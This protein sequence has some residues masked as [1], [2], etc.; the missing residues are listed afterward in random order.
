METL[1]LYIQTKF[2]KFYRRILPKTKAF[3]SGIKL[4]C[5]L[6]HVSIAEKQWNVNHL[7]AVVTSFWQE[8][9]TDAYQQPPNLALTASLYIEIE[10]RKKKNSL[11]VWT[12]LNNS[13]YMEWVASLRSEEKPTKCL[14]KEALVIAALPPHMASI[15]WNWFLF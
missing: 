2:T 1:M 6:V 7:F 10:S 4:L 5:P 8:I 12:L 13:A 3:I 14:Y 15:D 9:I 11:S